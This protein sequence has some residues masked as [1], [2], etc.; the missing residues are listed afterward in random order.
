MA[1]I[2]SACSFHTN[3]CKFC[4][5]IHYCRIPIDAKLML[6]S[7]FIW[8]SNHFD[9]LIWFINSTI[10]TNFFLW[11]KIFSKSQTNRL[12]KMF[13]LIWLQFTMESR[14]VRWTIVYNRVLCPSNRYVHIF[15]DI[16][17]VIF[18]INQSANGRFSSNL[19]KKP[20]WWTACRHRREQSKY[21]E[22]TWLSINA[23]QFDSLSWDC[24][25]VSTTSNKTVSIFDN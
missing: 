8:R 24:K 17:H 12:N 16:A 25:R 5:L 19:L 20:H 11:Q 3:S 7:H 23:A 18:P 22:E 14:L 1:S 4:F 15:D 9:A 13:Q 6:E 10:F 2:Q 21:Q